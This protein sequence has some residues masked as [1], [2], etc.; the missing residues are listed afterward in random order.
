MIVLSEVYFHAPTM[1]YRQ[2]PMNEHIFGYEPD[3]NEL[4][5]VLCPVLYLEIIYVKT[6]KSHVI[7]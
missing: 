5:W 4:T 3:S 6:E 7:D 2:K 1:P